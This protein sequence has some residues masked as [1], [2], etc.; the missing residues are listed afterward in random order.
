MCDSEVKAIQK[1]SKKAVE[2]IQKETKKLSHF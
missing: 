1:E 2:K